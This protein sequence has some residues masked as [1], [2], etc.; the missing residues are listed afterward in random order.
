MDWIGQ[1]DPEQNAW[2]TKM[3]EHEKNILR[4]GCVFR[5]LKQR[6][7]LMVGILPVECEVKRVRAVVRDGC[8]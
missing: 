2:E 6:E 3:Q 1:G 4:R 5:W 8:C 7:T